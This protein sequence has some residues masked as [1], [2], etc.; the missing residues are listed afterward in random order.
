LQKEREKRERK[1]RGAKME[2]SCDH[3]HKRETNVEEKK[4]GFG[5]W[6]D[7]RWHTNG[8]A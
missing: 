8:C 5:E 6:R 7:K 3:G 1:E 2:G 4:K